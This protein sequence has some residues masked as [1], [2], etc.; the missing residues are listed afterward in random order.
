[1]SLQRNQVNAAI[2]ASISDSLNRQ[3][4]AAVVR[5]VLKLLSN[6]LFNPEDDQLQI[7]HIAGLQAALGSTPENPSGVGWDTVPGTPTITATSI[8]ETSSVVDISGTL[9]TI[10][11]KSFTVPLAASGKK[12]VDAIVAS[13]ALTTPTYTRV[14]GDEVSTT[15]IAPTPTIGNNVLFVR[16]IDVTDGA[17]GQTVS[18]VV[19]SISVDGATP[20]LPDTN[21]L[22]S[23]TIN[24]STKAEKAISINT[25]NSTNTPSGNYTVALS[26]AAGMIDMDYTSANTVTVPT[27]PQGTQLI[28][29]QAGTGQTTLV[30]GSGVTFQGFGNQYKLSGQFSGATLIWKTSTIVRIMG[31]TTT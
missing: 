6:N 31:N 17:V 5:A 28:I 10:P 2:E 18:G 30:T 19:K 24:V 4:T 25:R 11:S 21:G 7:S 20:L 26:D 15:S 8:T 29:G 14:P 27:L 3:N 22:L 23:L 1:M 13:Y 16:Y 12:R 9:V